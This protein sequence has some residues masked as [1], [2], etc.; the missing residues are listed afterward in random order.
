MEFLTKKLS[1]L[2]IAAIFFGSFVPGGAAGQETIQEAAPVLGRILE[3]NL[4]SAG[5]EVNDIQWALIKERGLLYLAGV[6]LGNFQPHQ[7]DAGEKTSEDE[8]LWENTRRELQGQEPVK[9][10]QAQRT[11]AALEAVQQT[12]QKFSGRIPISGKEEVR[13]ILYEKIQ[14]P[15]LYMNSSLYSFQ[16]ELN[17]NLGAA[18]LSQYQPYMAGS[19]I[20]YVVMKAS[21]VIPSG[22][23]KKAEDAAVLSR[24]LGKKLA[25]TFPDEYWGVD[26]Q[27]RPGAMG[28]VAGDWGPVVILNMTFPFQ[29]ESK[30]TE[31][32]KLDL[33]DET[34]REMKGE[35]KAISNPP[36]YAFESTQPVEQVLMQKDV[37]GDGN[38]D[39]LFSGQKTKPGVNTGRFLA[40]MKEVLADFGGRV[41]GLTGDEDIT[42]LVF[43]GKKGSTIFG[44]DY[45]N[46][47][48]A[49]LGLV[50]KQDPQSN[51]QVLVD[52][53]KGMPWKYYSSPDVQSSASRSPSFI[54]RLPSDAFMENPE[55]APS[56]EEILK[57]IQME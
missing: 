12:L 24:V 18:F 19:K 3:K 35:S 4:K 16:R 52:K 26:M 51:R 45:S 1:V 31:G 47:Y 50:S 13:V 5:V 55:G 10:D 39:I 11:E 15:G 29:E 40:S 44:G 41:R 34:L 42:V 53:L 8:I 43:G 48:A 6:N 25:Q 56:R 9:L 49:I 2:L 30:E 22:D 37:D 46:A 32:K 36:T 17:K 7:K 54:L 20:E 14:N 27:G 57:K 21:G 28:M 23:A 38:L 33:W